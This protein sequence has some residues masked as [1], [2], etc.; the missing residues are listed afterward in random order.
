MD[1]VTPPQFRV[2]GGQLSSSIQYSLPL[3]LIFSDA[4]QQVKIIPELMEAWVRLNDF[5]I[6][7]FYVR[8]PYEALSLF[9][10]GRRKTTMWHPGSG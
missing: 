1:Q 7:P 2:G 4:G 6:K 8:T 3:Q 9:L 5:K 10:Q